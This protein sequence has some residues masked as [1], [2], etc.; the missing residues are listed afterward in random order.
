MQAKNEIDPE[1]IDHLES[2]KKI[3]ER[4]AQKA[5][6]GRAAFM[7]AAE[8]EFEGVSPFPVERHNHWMKSIRSKKTIQR[9]E[10]SRMFN[11]VT[12]ILIAF[13]LLL[14]GGGVTVA[15]AQ[16]SLPDQALY[17]VKLL[18]EDVRL[19]VTNDPEAQFQL[20]MDYAQHRAAEIQSMLQSGNVPDEAVQTRYQAQVEEALQY[21]LKLPDSQA[22]QALQQIQ[23]RLQ[24]QNQA[25][26]RVQT[27][28]SPAAEAALLRNRQMIQEHLQWVQG[29]LS[30]PEKFK[31]Q[32]QN[33]G[34][35]EQNPAMETESATRAP[36]DTGAG[37]P[38]TTGTPT[39][40]SGYGPGPGPSTT[41][42]PEGFYGPGPRPTDMPGRNGNH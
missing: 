33:R 19:K 16:G 13:S 15:A 34:G 1:V 41:A 24:E 25:L 11:F 21:A 22:I 36:A 18:S 10:H 8:K 37:N 2:L 20:A 9:K 23:T 6:E 14:G 28:G 30:D 42:T 3:P 5:E 39:P 27:N 4:D 12:T 35:Q 38:W 40:L 7:K 26:T 29:G 17:G 31:Q 32:M